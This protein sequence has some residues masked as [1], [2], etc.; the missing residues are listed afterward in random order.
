MPFKISTVSI[1]VS[2]GVSVLLSTIGGSV[3]DETRCDCKGNSFNVSI[4]SNR[5]SVSDRREDRII[6]QIDQS[7]NPL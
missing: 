6:E 7:L 1:Y 5:G 4:P 2:K 3:S